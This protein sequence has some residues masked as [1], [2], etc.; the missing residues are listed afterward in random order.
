MIKNIIFDFGNV[1]GWTL[2]DYTT[3][4]Y[5][6]DPEERK[7]IRKVVFDPEDWDLLNRGKMCHSNHIAV[8]FL[9]GLSFPVY[10]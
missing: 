6:T 10:Y 7:L 3:E 5:I 1:L 9:I 2:A 4:T 8:A